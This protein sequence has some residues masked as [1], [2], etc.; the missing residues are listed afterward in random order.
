MRITLLNA[1]RG[2]RLD[3]AALKRLTLAI[4]ALAQA[5]TPD[6]PPWQDVTVHLLDDVG[7]APVNAAI[8]A[9]AGAT[10][11]IT[12]R[13]EP[14]PGEPDGLVGEL[15][16]NVERARRA[17]PKRGVWS[18]DRELALYLAHGF[19]HLTGAD[20]ATPAER[21]R[22]RRRELGWLKRLALTALFQTGKL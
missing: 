22:M 10:D 21:A 12:Q 15:F 16:V 3:M 13:Y 18:A 14:V 2:F 8:M 1:Q 7:I 11:V 6:E 4:G 19:D 17:A 5:R 20:D 9:H